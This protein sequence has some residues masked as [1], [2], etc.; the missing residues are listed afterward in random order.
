MCK[1]NDAA[2]VNENMPS[3]LA[4]PK[5]NFNWNQ[6]YKPIQIT[7]KLKKSAC[8]GHIYGHN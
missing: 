8:N 5:D 3:L 7:P 4:A 1:L 6:H 2:S